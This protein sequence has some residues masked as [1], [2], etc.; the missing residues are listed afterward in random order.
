MM[1]F[2]ALLR[3]IVAVVYL[4][5]TRNKV[6]NIKAILFKL[7]IDTIMGTVL[8]LFDILTLDLDV[9]PNE[10]F[11]SDIDSLASWTPISIILDC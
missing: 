2:V 11:D 4:N 3:L 6:M 5:C 7:F 8:G 1:V 9:M 10:S